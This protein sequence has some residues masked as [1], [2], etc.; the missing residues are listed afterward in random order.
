MTCSTCPCA[1]HA[2]TTDGRLFFCRRY[3]PVDHSWPIVGG[4]EWCFEHPAR[5][6]LL[7]IRDVGTDVSGN[8]ITGP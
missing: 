2:A 7:S 4:E 8:L 6:R 1:S 3:P 5:K